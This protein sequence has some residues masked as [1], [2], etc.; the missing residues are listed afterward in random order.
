MASQ[1]QLED[2]HP[3]HGLYNNH[4]NQQLLVLQEKHHLLIDEQ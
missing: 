3:S 1:Q 2:K 4:L